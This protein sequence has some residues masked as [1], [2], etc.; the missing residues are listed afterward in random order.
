MTSP[1]MLGLVE[2]TGS[3]EATLVS[4]PHTTPICGKGIVSS[5]SGGHSI[6]NVLPFVPAIGE[7]KERQTPEL[8][9]LLQF[10]GRQIIAVKRVLHL[11]FR[12]LEIYLVHGYRRMD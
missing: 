2:V 12:A 1:P 7:N 3:L 5:R 6:G 8:S 9:D 4:S 11:S 10:S